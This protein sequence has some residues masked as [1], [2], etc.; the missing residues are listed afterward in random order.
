MNEL[1]K[2]LTVNSIHQNFN[3]FE[4]SIVVILDMMDVGFKSS[5]TETSSHTIFLYLKM[6]LFEMNKRS[7]SNIL[8]FISSNE[9]F[10]SLI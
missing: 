4:D 1:S 10:N 7:S 3:T 6:I 8:I 9:H 2:Y 5:V